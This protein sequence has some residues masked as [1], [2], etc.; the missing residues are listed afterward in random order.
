MISWLKWFLFSVDGRAG[1]FHMWM[2]FLIYI[3]GI[4]FF[5][6]PMGIHSPN[7]WPLKVLAYFLCFVYMIWIYV[8]VGVKRCHDH[9]WSGQ[10]LWLLYIPVVNIFMFWMLFIWPGKNEKNRFGNS[11]QIFKIPDFPARVSVSSEESK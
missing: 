8:T 9:G 10:R 6:W 3:L 1:I 5:I 2:A 4:P 7:L 11:A